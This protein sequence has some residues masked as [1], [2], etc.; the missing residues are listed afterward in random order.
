MKDPHLIVSNNLVIYI[1][2]S[3]ECYPR[4]KL[5]YCYA[6]LGK[7]NAEVSDVVITSSISFYD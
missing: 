7:S 1:Q 3:I 6:F 4:L 2:G 5:G